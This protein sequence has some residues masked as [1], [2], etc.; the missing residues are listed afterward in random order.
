[1]AIQS[2]R[3]QATEDFFYD[4]ILPSKGCGWARIKS[5]VARKLDMIEAANALQDLRIPPSNRLEKLRG[6]LE[7]YYSI[8]IN[9]QWRIVF[10]WTDQGPEEVGII[11]YH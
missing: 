4:G 1:M 10:R 2:F 9:N 3:D 5:I 11:D 6:D 8:R 7:D